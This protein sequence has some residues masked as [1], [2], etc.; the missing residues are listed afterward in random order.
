MLYFEQVLFLFFIIIGPIIFYQFYCDDEEYF[1]SHWKPQYIFFALMCCSSSLLMHFS[2]FQV[3]D[4]PVSFFSLVVLYTF[5]YGNKKL[6]LFLLLYITGYDFIINDRDNFIFYLATAWV[7]I[8]PIVIK[9]D[10]QAYSKRNKIRY[11]FFI[12]ASVCFGYLIM[13][14]LAAIS[15][16]DVHVGDISLSMILFV[17]ICYV[18]IFF[19]MVYLTEFLIE[20]R[21]LKLMAQE[22]EKLLIVSELAASVAHE[23][24]NPLT[25]VKGFVKL[26]EPEVNDTSKEYLRLVLSELDRTEAIITDYLNLAKKNKRLD[27]VFS[28]SDMLETVYSVMSIYTGIKGIDLTLKKEE[29]LYIFGDIGKMKQVCYNIIKNGVEAISHS[30]GKISLQC[31][32]K[33]DEVVIEIQDNGI[34]MEKHEMLRVGEAFYTSKETGTGLGIMITKAIVEEHNGII[35]FESEKGIGTKVTMTLKRCECE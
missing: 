19:F 9:A 11:S 25:V 13:F 29:E 27:S 7:F 17:F 20:N 6:G 30:N 33:A 4:F 31:Y 18:S 2:V 32:C 8:I 12:S 23:V 15:N 34:G 24:R 3:L 14:W 1:P 10:W 21:R 5:L 22:S 35:R 16:N 26:V 28:I